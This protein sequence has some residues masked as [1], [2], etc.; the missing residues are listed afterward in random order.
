MGLPIGGPVIRLILDASAISG[1]AIAPG[2]Q[3]MRQEAQ[4]TTAAISDGWKQMS[5]QLRASIAQESISLDG[6]RQK[7][8]EIINAVDLEIAKLRQKNDLTNKELSTLKAV[9]LERERQID[10]IKRGVSIGITGGTSSALGQVSTQTTLGVERVL[11]SLVNRYLGSAAG[12]L[13]RTVRDV[14]Y[15]ANQANGGS[16]GI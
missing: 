5:A 14:S 12:A 1:S 9:T 3:Q 11:D 10:A 7:R 8:F 13:T 16:G 6:I 2:L 15:Y 4:K